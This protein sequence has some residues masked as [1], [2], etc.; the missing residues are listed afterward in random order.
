[1]KADLA[2]IEAS[3]AEID[4]AVA[5]GKYKDAGAKLDAAQQ[6]ADKIKADIEAAIAAKSAA[7]K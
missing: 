7:R 1:M 2:G 5:A 3:F 6:G 4:G